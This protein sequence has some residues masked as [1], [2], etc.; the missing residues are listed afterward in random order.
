MAT[1]LTLMLNLVLMY[2]EK[3][4]THAAKNAACP[5]FV[6]VRLSTMRI[7]VTASATQHRIQVFTVRGVLSAGTTQEKDPG[8]SGMEDCDSGGPRRSFH[9]WSRSLGLILIQA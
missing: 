4:T 1:I 3:S 9:I 5:K 7:I 2:V 6:N 8:C